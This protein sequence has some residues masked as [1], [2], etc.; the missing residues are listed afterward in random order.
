MPSF[1]ARV[2]SQINTLYV[3]R[4]LFFNEKIA[5]N[6]KTTNTTNATAAQPGILIPSNCHLTSAQLPSPKNNAV[7]ASE[8]GKVSITKLKAGPQ[9]GTCSGGNSCSHICLP[10]TTNPPN[11]KSKPTN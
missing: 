2:Q 1:S 7:S 4:R 8:S 10:A 6:V 11:A 9:A 5:E 3:L